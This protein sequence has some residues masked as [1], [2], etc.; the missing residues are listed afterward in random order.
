MTDEIETK[1]KTR[2]RVKYTAAR[3]IRSSGKSVLVEWDDG[4]LQRG[5]IPISAYDAEKGRV[6]E[7]VLNASIP[8]GVDWSKAEILPIDPEVLDAELKARGI[9]TKDDLKSNPQLVNVIILRMAGLSRAKL[10]QLKE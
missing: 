5:F 9:W 2:K 3:L 7:N 4:K 10:V 1:P 8:Y 6:E